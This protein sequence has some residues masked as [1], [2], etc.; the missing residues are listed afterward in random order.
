MLLYNKAM[1]III[2]ASCIMAVLTEEPEREI[3]L[4]KVKGANLYSS[5]C[6]PY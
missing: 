3:V 1:D 5:A 6:L 4:E 2:D